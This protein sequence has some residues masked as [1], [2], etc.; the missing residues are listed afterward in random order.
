MTDKL[1]AWHDQRDRRNQRRC[2]ANDLR[3]GRGEL[4]EVSDSQEACNHPNSKRDLKELARER[5]RAYRKANNSGVGVSPLLETCPGDRSG[6]RILGQDQ[7]QNKAAGEA[8][9]VR[10][11]GDADR[12]HRRHGERRDTTKELGDKPDPD[13]E[14]SR[15]A[16]DP[17]EENR[18]EDRDLGAR[19]RDGIGAKNPGDRPTRCQAEDGEL[20]LLKVNPHKYEEVARLEV[21]EAG[22]PDS[23]LEY[24]CWAAPILSHGLLYVRGKDRLICLEVDSP[25][26]IAEVV[27]VDREKRK[28]GA[29]AAPITGDQHVIGRRDDAMLA[30]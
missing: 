20:S 24:P 19:K 1:E 17:E 5:Y 12:L 30:A 26:L 7:H 11:P 21:R 14:K 18:D 10:P 8:A 6:R 3:D 28:P 13:H 9:H 25:D 27:E 22:S 15:H 2:Q 4:A 29:G 16:E 23:L